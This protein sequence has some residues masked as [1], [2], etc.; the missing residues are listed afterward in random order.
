MSEKAKG[1]VSLRKK[2]TTKRPQ[3]SAPRQIIPTQHDDDSTPSLHPPPLQ[4]SQS[5]DTAPRNNS[6]T[7]Q[8]S[9]AVPRPRPSLGGPDRTADLVKR[10]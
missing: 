9:L 5:S 6:Q 7:S 3:I 10:R 8:T 1:I 2:K 4:H